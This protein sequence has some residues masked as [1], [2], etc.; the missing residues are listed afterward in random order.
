MAAKKYWRVLVNSSSHTYAKIYRVYLRGTLDGANLATHP[1]TG[2]GSSSSTNNGSSTWAWVDNDS[3][4]YSLIGAG[5]P[6]WTRFEFPSATEVVQVDL[7][8]GTYDSEVMSG[9]IQSSDDALTWADEISFTT[10]GTPGTTDKFYFGPEEHIT[11]EI[12]LPCISTFGTGEAA[13]NL[14]SLS[15]SASCGG[16]AT[17]TLPK[18]T[19]SGT[20]RGQEV[21]LPP[22]P[23]LLA[24]VYGPANSAQT[25][26]AL[27]TSASGHDASGERDAQ[28][29]LP[30]LNVSAALG[31]YAHATVPKLVVAATGT[32]PLILSAAPSLPSLSV[33]AIG[34]VSATAH[35]EPLL[36]ALT[37]NVH[38]GAVCSV[39]IGGLTLS[40]SG[41]TGRAGAVQATLPL[42][43][44]LADATA[45]KTASADI[46]LPSLSMATGVRTPIS[47][48]SLNL[49]AIGTA[50]V[51]VTYEAYA[52]NL[53]HTSDKT[54]DELTRYTNFP[55]D[56]IVRYKDSYYG[57][58][59]TGLYLLEGTTDD[60]DPIPWEVETHIT[61]FGNPKIKTVE[62]AYF[63]GRLGPDATV[64]LSVGE[65]A[66]NSYSYTTPRGQTV[67]NYRQVFGKGAKARYFS[68]GVSGEDEIELDSLELAVTELARRI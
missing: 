63:G 18:V 41:A 58:N 15:L 38:S 1:T 34:R 54:N 40:A 12:E 17:A 22:L 6:Q 51:A 16:K 9:V 66:D 37:A 67:Q 31:G 39:T 36:P 45:G 21:T 27:S 33:T 24:V 44:A 8:R 2:T 19:V 64:T 42:F 56:R 29:T 14:P 62:R 65:Q 30:A 3:A 26:P 47:L 11:C 52:L 32:V 28:I 68:L 57:M 53:K 50:T 4:W 13:V 61:D 20:R 23:S 59:A 46:T 7:V 10:S 55:F 60:G 35:A 25:L 5:L 49:V 43:V 48:P